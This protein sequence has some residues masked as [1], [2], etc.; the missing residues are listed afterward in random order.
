M[1]VSKEFVRDVAVLRERWCSQ[2]G[3]EHHADQFFHSKSLILKID[4]AISL[5]KFVANSMQ[6]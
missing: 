6:F 1:H 5:I 4:L 2:H 3:K